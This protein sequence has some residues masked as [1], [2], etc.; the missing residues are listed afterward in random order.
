MNK[1]KN[2][3]R[4]A[5]KTEEID[6]DLDT[7]TNAGGASRPTRNSSNV[8]KSAS[9]SSSKRKRTKTANRKGNATGGIHQRGDKRVIG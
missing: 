8:R 9:H 1:K 2:T 4:I 5:K 7:D 6:Q 3:K